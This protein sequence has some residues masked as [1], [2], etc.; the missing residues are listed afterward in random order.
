MINFY[1]EWYFII[2]ITKAESSWKTINQEEFIGDGSGRYLNGH[3]P[4][5]YQWQTEQVRRTRWRFPILVLGSR[6]C[7]YLVKEKSICNNALNLG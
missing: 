3:S 4:R 7:Q 1:P 5:I 6:E 2:L